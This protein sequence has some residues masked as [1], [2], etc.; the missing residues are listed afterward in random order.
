MQAERDNW[1]PGRTWHGG[2]QGKKDRPAEDKLCLYQVAVVGEAVRGLPLSLE[3]DNTLTLCLSKLRAPIES[4]HIVATTM[5]ACVAA[6]ASIT[7]RTRRH[8]DD[9]KCLPGHKQ[10]YLQPL[11]RPTWTAVQWLII[12]QRLSFFPTSAV[13]LQRAAACNLL[14]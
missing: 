14:M 2:A 10:P 6:D 13:W 5:L 1:C 11:E 3:V 7:S 4:L 12:S 9:G 8:A